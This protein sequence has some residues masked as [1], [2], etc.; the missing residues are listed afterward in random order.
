MKECNGSIVS[1]LHCDLLKRKPEYCH[2]DTQTERERES[3]GNRDRP[4]LMEVTRSPHALRMRPILL[5]VT[6][7]PRPLTTPPVT[8]TYFIA[9][10]F[11]SCLCFSLH[12]PRNWRI[13]KNERAYSLAQAHILEDKNFEQKTGKTLLL[14]LIVV[15]MYFNQH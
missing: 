6:P 5:A 2:T 14:P 4:I 1:S 3:Q 8:K 15:V 11:F 10:R 12:N 7:L 9:F 13:Q